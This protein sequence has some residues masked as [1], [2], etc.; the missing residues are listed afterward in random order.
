MGRRLKNNAIGVALGPEGNFERELP[1][2]EIVM[3]SIGTSGADISALCR[4]VVSIT[5]L[6][7]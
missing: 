5:A 4:L 6:N 7:L 1:D 2:A 3:N